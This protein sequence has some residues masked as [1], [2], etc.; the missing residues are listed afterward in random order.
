MSLPNANGMKV[1]ENCQREYP[2]SGGNQR[3]CSPECRQEAYGVP[4][5]DG[6][7]SRYE[8]STGVIRERAPD[9][10]R[11]WEMDHARLAT[12]PE[13][14]GE[15]RWLWREV[16]KPGEGAQPLS[17]FACGECVTKRARG[18]LHDRVDA[19]ELQGDDSEEEPAEERRRAA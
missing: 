14:Q 5:K 19:A 7:P 17:G 2:P 1:C 13:C 15:E 4:R 10:V 16:D 11:H 12:C 6:S 9:P 18:G 3:Y 8:R